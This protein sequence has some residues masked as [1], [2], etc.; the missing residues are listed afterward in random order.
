MKDDKKLT[1]YK[2]EREQRYQDY[3][4]KPGKERTTRK[5]FNKQYDKAHRAVGL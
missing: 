4:T 3:I 1:D 5:Q 2:W